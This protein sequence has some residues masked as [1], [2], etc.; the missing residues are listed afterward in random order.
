MLK[1]DSNMF[2]AIHIH[3]HYHKCTFSQVHA[4]ER[5]AF[6]QSLR[7]CGVVY[8]YATNKMTKIL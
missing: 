4:I 2:S 5:L 3:L 6:K 8:N 1:A 7:I